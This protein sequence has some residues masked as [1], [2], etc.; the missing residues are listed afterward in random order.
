VAYSLYLYDTATG[1]ADYVSQAAARLPELLQDARKAL[2]CPHGC[3][4]ACQGCVLTHDT[5]Y[6]LED[7]D[8]HRAL[9]LL[10]DAFLNGLALPAELR[11]FGSYSQLEMEPLI[12]A[13]NREGQ[14]LAVTELRVYLGG[15]TQ[16]WEPLAWRLRGE[17]IRWSQNGASVRLI[18]S[19]VTLEGLNASQRDEL[20][21]LI[22]YTGAELW[23]STP[24]GSDLPLILE[25]GAADKR[26]R[27]AAQAISALVPRPTWGG[28]EQGGP[29][30]RMKETQPLAP[31]PEAWRRVV[32]ADLRQI[33]PGLVAFSITHELD[34]SSA[35]FGERV[36]TH[37]AKQVPSLAERLHGGEPLESVSYT[38]RYLRSPLVL[39]LLH[40][41]LQGLRAYPGGLTPST[42]V[43]VETATLDRWGVESPRLLFHDWRESD[44]RRQVAN[45]WFQETWPGFSWHEAMARDLPHARE[46]TMRWHDGECWVFRLDQ[47]LG[48][49]RIAPRTHAEFPFEHDVARQITNLREA[50]VGIEPLN[51]GYPTYWYCG[52]R[53]S[54]SV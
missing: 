26:V 17:L 36:W 54:C 41:W 16:E 12:L 30:V 25:L 52:R 24:S 47:G 8:R 28:G 48:Y 53:E 4:A 2:D 31:L 23:Q 42:Q 33:A 21:A 5:Q 51:A 6:H 35:T 45:Q 13:L 49:W 27:W 7:L 18:A 40:E 44:D 19:S 9:E 22:A 11:A 34:G 3:D 14:R 15:E 43:R 32:P 39:L 46:L 1:G 10:S 38:D 29:F 37:L 20:A 50:N